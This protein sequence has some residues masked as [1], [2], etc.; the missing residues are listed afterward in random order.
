MIMSLCKKLILLPLMIQS[1]GYAISILLFFY[2][3]LPSRL[4]RMA[5]PSIQ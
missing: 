2:K 1:N 4:D 3:A 5:L